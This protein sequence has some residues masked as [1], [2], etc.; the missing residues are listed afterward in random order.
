MASHGGGILIIE[1]LSKTYKNVEA[2]K[3]IDVALEEP[4]VYGFL[5]PNG[6]GKSTTFKVISSLVRPT[7]GRVLVDGV[8][9]QKNPRAAVSCIGVHFDSPAFYP[10]LSGRHNLDVFNRWLDTAV[11]SA[12]I[13]ALLSMV[14]LADAAH[15]KTGGYSWGMKQRLGLA[16]ALLSD[17]KLV[18]LDEPTNGLDPSGI[19]DMRRL[20]PRLARD[21]GRTVFLSSHRMEEVENVCDHVTIIH[22]GAIVAAGAPAELAADDGVIEVHC[23]DADAAAELLRAFDGVEQ[24]DV[25]TKSRLTVASAETSAS[26]INQFLVER[27]VAVE[28]VVHKRE[29]LEQV[30]FRLTGSA[31]G[32]EA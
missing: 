31:D 30:F 13:D 11:D 8:D 28:Q 27:G 18:L 14:G 10:H 3:G 24:V 21:E 12:R 6:A 23:T 4:G 9:V 20:L 5:G 25:L 32:G 22:E 29:S 7:S 16:S 2:L 26:R 17:P 15:R 1:R 19:A